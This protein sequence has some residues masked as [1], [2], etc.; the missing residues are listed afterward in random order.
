MDAVVDEHNSLLKQFFYEPMQTAVS[1]SMRQSMEVRAGFKA[2]SDMAKFKDEHYHKIGKYLHLQSDVN[3]ARLLLDVNTRK[4]IIDAF[5]SIF[6]HKEYT[7]N[8]YVELINK[9]F[10]QIQSVL[11][12]KYKKKMTLDMKRYASL[13]KKYA[14]EMGIDI[15]QI[16]TLH[17]S[18]P[19]AKRD[20]YFP[21]GFKKVD[22]SVQLHT[23]DEIE[24]QDEA[25]ISKKRASAPTTFSPSFL[26]DVAATVEKD[27]ELENNARVLIERN[28]DD[29][30][31]YRNIIPEAE[32][33]NSILNH[34][35]TA[36]DFNMPDDY[37]NF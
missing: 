30:S 9:N 17:G 21:I 8:E 7:R 19:V 29:T 24:K 3:T 37:I 27:F 20:N 26:K 11:R 33:Q 36:S 1:N 15:E 14:D 5:P 13:W 28:I 35:S 6:K 25:Q 4:E 34:L 23:F 2:I 18:H 31:F 10:L 12:S 22:T 32:R 16:S